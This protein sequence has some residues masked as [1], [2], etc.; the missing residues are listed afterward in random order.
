MTRISSSW[1]AFHKKVFPIVWFG[2]LAAVVA[3][4]LRSGAPKQNRGFVA[5]P[6]A[7]MLLG[8]FLMKKLVFDLVDEVYDC[9][10][11]LLIK[12][13]GE[14]AR[15]PLSNIMNVSVSTVTNPPRITLKL[16]APVSFGDEITFS[17][18]TGLRLNPFAKSRVAEDLILR[19]HRAQSA[20]TS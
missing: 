18:V 15:V 11:A 7:M 9:G 6:I 16:I 13:G 10:D 19:V 8:F 14:E 1:T 20:R 5:I 4:G 12:N 17:P 3:A 2:F